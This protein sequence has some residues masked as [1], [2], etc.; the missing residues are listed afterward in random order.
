[1]PR[2]PTPPTA[3]PDGTAVAAAR[4]RF[5]TAEPVAPD[6]VRA[7]ILASWWRSRERNVAADHI[8][9]DY[10]R[11][12]NLDSPL[13][14]SALP[15]LR[16]LRDNLAGQAISIILTDPHGLVLARLACDTDL[17]RHLDRVQLAPGFSYAEDSVGTNGIGTALEGGGTMYVFGHEHYAENLENLACAATPI[18]H[19]ITGKT[20]GAVD[21]TC[22]ERDAGPLLVSLAKTTAGQIRQALVRDGGVGEFELLQEYLRARRRTNGVVFAFNYETVMLNEY[23]QRM[24]SPTDQA[25]LQGRATEMLTAVHRGPVT[26]ELADGSMV[27]MYCRPVRAGDSAAGGVVHVQPV[28]AEAPVAVPAPA[29]GRLILPGLVGS[30]S[31]WVRGC[32][33]IDAAYAGGQWLALHG[34]AGVG[35]LATIRAVHHGREPTARLRTVDCADAAQREWLPDLRRALADSGVRLVLR[36]VDRLDDRQL[37]A[38]TATLRAAI[39]AAR[40]TP[41]WVAATLLPDRQSAHLDTLL[42][43]FPAAAQLPPLRHHIEDIADLVPLFLDRLSPRGRLRCSPEAMQMLLRANWPGNTEQLWQVLRQ[44]VRHR[45][46]GTILPDDLPPE[47]HALSRRLLS[48]LES[49]E[50][51]AIVHSLA[52]ASGNKVKAARSLG[53]SRATIYRK[54]REYGIVAP[55]VPAH[56]G[57]P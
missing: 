33:R 25:V 47:C 29:S 34:E 55:P 41:P 31:L 1:M 27:R 19:P 51:D 37:T 20:V 13:T 54:I 24:L 14:S 40:G 57:S 4:V 44:V 26:V 2:A 35:K 3:E 5:L 39:A 38:L 49:M 45:R 43:L 10:L 17:E 9:L 23:A 48:P 50:R 32:H 22:W 8:R 53:M 12:P 21:L 7:P 28:E 15:V 36:H 46:I 42:Q 16:N 52:D 11:D 18:H 6:A 30:G 56:R